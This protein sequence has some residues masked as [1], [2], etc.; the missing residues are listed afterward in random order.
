MLFY[1]STPLTGCFFNFSQCIW[2]CISSGGQSTFYRDNKTERSI[3]KM[4]AAVAF[5]KE[6]NIIQA[7]E[8]LEEHICLNVNF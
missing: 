8:A 1:T 4:F 2:S 3:F 6:D 7:Y 5:I